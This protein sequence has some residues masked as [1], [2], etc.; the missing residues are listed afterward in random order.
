VYN[1]RTENYEVNFR[2]K[3]DQRAFYIQ[4]FKRDVP[5]RSLFRAAKCLN[6]L[7]QTGWVEAEPPK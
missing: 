6:T 1:I 7:L 5:A 4:S 2:C 3:L